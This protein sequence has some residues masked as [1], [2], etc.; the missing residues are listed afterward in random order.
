MMSMGHPRQDPTRLAVNC[1]KVSNGGR[2]SSNN[3]SGGWHMVNKGAWLRRQDMMVTTWRLFLG[4]LG[5]FEKVWGGVET[6][7]YFSKKY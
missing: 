3:E 2:S 1:C 7:I 4:V 5:D 6:T